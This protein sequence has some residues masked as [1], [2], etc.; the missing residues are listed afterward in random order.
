MHQPAG[1][2]RLSAMEPSSRCA[3]ST[4]SSNSCSS[5]AALKP[6]VL[7]CRTQERHPRPANMMRQ[8]APEPSSQAA[9]RRKLPTGR[10]VLP[11]R[12]LPGPRLTQVGSC[13]YALSQD[14]RLHVQGVLCFPTVLCSSS[15]V[16][17]L[18]CCFKYRS[19]SGGGLAGYQGPTHQQAH[20][21][22][23]NQ[24]LEN[25][26]VVGVGLFG[27]WLVYILLLTGKPSWFTLTCTW[28]V[29]AAL[30]LG[31]LVASAGKR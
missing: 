24:L 1:T 19:Q 6:C 30:G 27:L 16:L 26:V 31:W 21:L 7:L 22:A 28:W 3:S 9:G 18:S 4:P 25:G 20:G 15:S 23:G 13:L 29:G 8:R 5:W 17:Q 14:S 12:A 2:T 11:V 10:A